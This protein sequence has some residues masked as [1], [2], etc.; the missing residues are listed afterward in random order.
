[1]NTP[2]KILASVTADKFVGRGPELARLIAHASDAGILDVHAAPDSG[3]SE[4]LR[5]LYDHFYRTASGV[6]PFYFRL[7][8]GE[9][10]SDAAR[11]WVREFITQAAAFDRRVPELIAAQPDIHSLLGLVS[12]HHRGWIEGAAGLI[13]A[14]TPLESLLAVPFRAA[15]N[16]VKSF[17]LIDEFERGAESELAD[18]MRRVFANGSLPSVFCFARRSR[19][20]N[21]SAARLHI[22]LPVRADAAELLAAYAEERC[23][24]LS[25]EV[26]DLAVVHLGA[27][28]VY[29]RGIVDAAAARDMPLAS[30]ANFAAIYT[31]ELFGISIGRKI[32]RELD[33]IAGDPDL[34]KEIFKQLCATQDNGPTYETEWEMRLGGTA[35]ECDAVLSLLH[36]REFITRASG[37]VFFC[38][39]D[40]IL[41][42]YL[43]ARRELETSGKTRAR[44]VAEELSENFGRSQK[45]LA[46]MYRRDAA[47]GLRE[48]LSSFTGR[49][50]AAVSIDFAKF[51]TELKGR[52]DDEQLAK[53]AATPDRIALPNVLFS[54]QAADVYPSI[55]RVA[56][57]ERTAIA[58]GVSDAGDPIIWLAAE[59][60]S[61]FAASLDL[62]EYW[63]DRLEMAALASEFKNYRLWL[64]T[65][66]GF[67]EA[68]MHAL[69]ERNAF[70][71]SYR[72]IELLR[73]ELE[74]AE[75]RPNASPEQFEITIPMGGDSEI[76]A[77][78]FAEDVAERSGFSQRAINQIKT[79]LVE[80]CINAS[81][82]SLSPERKIHLTFTPLRDRL[83][84]TVRNRGIRLKDRQTVARDGKAGQRRGWGLELIAK[85][86]DSVEVLP[87]DDGTAIKIT[88]L[89]S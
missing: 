81:E 31:D 45:L 58:F 63:L 88:K 53:I 40:G 30:F 79:A 2:E 16:G 67:D 4:T 24:S 59:F 13:D 70:G 10:A 20:E 17:V 64:V 80:A 50:V 51:D 29:L 75:S 62:T 71:S 21:P 44:V 85:L 7:R 78:S 14:D 37:R 47:I 38:G 6:V 12:E 86:S 46:R 57:V 87:T 27:R 15:A 34:E 76:V 77:A 65:R 54:V 48:L 55:G 18:A 83:E 72:Q 23:V 39:S 73:I 60:D 84:I 36:E 9:T 8:A 33:R 35:A 1:M 41:I 69:A 43:R 49:T 61:K 89:L 22:D 25:D 82:H 68:A 42:D 19:P 5:Q 28:P 3:S 66:E 56:D 52:S 32:D 11:R 74:L 26:R